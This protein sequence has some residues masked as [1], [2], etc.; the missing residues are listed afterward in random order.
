[1]SLV[2]GTKRPIR[3]VCY[4]AAIGGK[5]TYGGYRKTDAIGP[6]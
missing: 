5:R 1:M 3:D 2:M 6:R 4:S